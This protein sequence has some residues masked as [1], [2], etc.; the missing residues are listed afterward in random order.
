MIQCSFCGRRFNDQAAPRHI[1]FCEQQSKK[2]GNKLNSTQN[3]K[4]KW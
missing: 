1:A 3:I 4:K 2:I